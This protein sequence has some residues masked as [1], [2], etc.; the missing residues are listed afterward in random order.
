MEFQ[1]VELDVW[2]NSE[3]GYEVNGAYFT[4]EVI[5]ITEEE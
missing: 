3:E 1:V 4:D 5:T 2:G